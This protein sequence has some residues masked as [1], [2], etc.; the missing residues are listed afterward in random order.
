MFNVAIFQWGKSLLWQE[1]D[2]FAF[3]Q[4][5]RLCTQG[6][7]L[8]VV[9]LS[10][11]SRSSIQTSRFCPAVDKFIFWHLL[12]LYIFW[13]GGQVNKSSSQVQVSCY[14]SGGQALKILNV[15]P[16]V[17]SIKLLPKLS[18]V[19]IPTQQ[20]FSMTYLSLNILYRKFEIF[21]LHMITNW[22]LEG[23]HQSTTG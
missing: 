18:E 6:A 21:S 2:I 10:G 20:L 15:M 1:V 13:G 12:M 23:K 4:S 16:C 22:Y 9:L 14:L 8:M 5:M 7:T 11:T 17:P 3:W 19:H